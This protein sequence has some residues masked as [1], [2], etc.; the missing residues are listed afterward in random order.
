[1]GLSALFRRASP[2]REIR[3]NSSWEA[4]RL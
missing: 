1:V 3:Q 2:E 4:F